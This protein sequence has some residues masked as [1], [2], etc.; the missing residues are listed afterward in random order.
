MPELEKMIVSFIYGPLS[1]ISELKEFG[2]KLFD[3]VKEY[4]PYLVESI[5]NYKIDVQNPFEY[6]ESLSTRPEIKIDR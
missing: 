3:I 1:K 2:E 5:E 6:M 4:I